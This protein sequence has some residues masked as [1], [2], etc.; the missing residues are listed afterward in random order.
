MFS[1]ERER[2]EKKE[3]VNGIGSE[4][5][6]GKETDVYFEKLKKENS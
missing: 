6:M 5:R 2:K 4:N 3:R 1:R